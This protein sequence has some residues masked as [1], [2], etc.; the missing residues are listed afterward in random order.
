MPPAPGRYVGRDAVVQN[1]VEEGF[2]DLERLRAIITA[3]NRQPAIAF[4]LWHEGEGCL[5]ATD[6]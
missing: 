6:D 3:A 5:S 2:A 1:W 4:Y